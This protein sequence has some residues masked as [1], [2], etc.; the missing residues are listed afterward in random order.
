MSDYS[1]GSLPLGITEE[2]YLNGYV[3][4]LRNPIIGSILFKLNY[5]E[6]FGT[7]IRRINDLYRESELKPFFN[8]S[9]NSIQVILPVVNR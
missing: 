7:G 1:P 9:A 5:I 4:S 6:M 3:S 8:V 2:E